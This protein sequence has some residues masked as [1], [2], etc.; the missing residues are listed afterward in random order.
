MAYFGRYMLGTE[1]P[2]SV[3]TVDADQLPTAPDVPPVLKIWSATTLVLSAQ[4]PVA[5]RFG[6]TQNKTFFI[7][8]L[9]LGGAYSAGLYDVTFSWDI[10][11]FAGVE[12]GNFEVVAGGH[13][14][15][16]II[17]MTLYHRPEADYVVWQNT[18]GKLQRSRNPRVT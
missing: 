7:Y 11:S 3:L 8:P 13:S 1:I 4:M 9:F 2:L 10:S 16:A 18:A 17:A 5:D 12:A 6:T 15:G 14:D